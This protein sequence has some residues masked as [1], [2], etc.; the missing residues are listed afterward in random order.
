[1]VDC[2]TDVCTAP[3][4]AAE[5]D[6]PAGLPRQDDG[7]GECEDDAQP[8][9]VGEREVRYVKHCDRAEEDCRGRYRR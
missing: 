8:D 5:D 2:P 6:G 7:A 4:S 3:E 1:M 9:E